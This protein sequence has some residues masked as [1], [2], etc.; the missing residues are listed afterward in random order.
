MLKHELKSKEWDLMVDELVPGVFKIPAFDNDFCD[1]LVSRLTAVEWKSDRHYNAP[2]T[3][4]MLSDVDQEIYKQYKSVLQDY[5]HN[6]ATYCFSHTQGVLVDENFND[7]TFVAKYTSDEQPHL[8]LHHD[9]DHVMYTANTLLNDNFT[10]G[11]T[12][13]VGDRKF[14]GYLAKPNKGELIIHPGNRKYQHGSRPVHSG[15]RYI[16]I[17]FMRFP[18]R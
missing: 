9:G 11:G 16:L 5:V 15:V 4:V 18:V 1:K 8:S 14:S 2:T 12:Y 6:M 10:G 3:D 7:Y 17:S 13:F